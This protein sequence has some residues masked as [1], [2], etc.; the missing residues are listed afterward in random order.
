MLPKSLS[1]IKRLTTGTEF[2]SGRQKCLNM[3]MS[4]ADDTS[5]LVSH[6]K[7]KGNFK[8]TFCLNL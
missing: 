2:L 6:E 4:L 3:L 7:V 1:F 5:L 8:N